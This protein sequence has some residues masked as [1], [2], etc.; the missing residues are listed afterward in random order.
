METTEICDSDDSFCKYSR[1]WKTEKYHENSNYAQKKRS[2]MEDH[3]E[4][5]KNDRKSAETCVSV[6]HGLKNVVSQ[7]V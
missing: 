1:D 7:N 6:N 5:H 3:V 4:K 2:S